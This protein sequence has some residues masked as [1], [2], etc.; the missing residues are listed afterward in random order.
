MLKAKGYEMLGI[1]S[2]PTLVMAAAEHGTPV[3]VADASALPFTSG[4][5]D[6]AISFMAFQDIDNMA[7]AISEAA[8]CLRAGGHLYLAVLHPIG[9][10]GDFTSETADASF[11]IERSY[12]EQRRR[13]DV[14]ERDGI[15]MTFNQYHR[16]LQAYFDGLERA[17]LVVKKLREIQPGPTLLERLPH[18]A[19]WTKVPIFLHI[20]AAKT[21]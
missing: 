10:A 4:S 1:D 15:S 12:L 6:H 14:V 8:R 9:S 18:A 16:P 7:A 19:R 3:V 17:G 5:V 20:V 13:N 11:L 21:P 2:S